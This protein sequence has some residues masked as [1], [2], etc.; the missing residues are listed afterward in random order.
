MTKTMGSI[1]WP[2]TLVTRLNVKSLKSLDYLLVTLKFHFFFE[3]NSHNF[4]TKMAKFSTLL[5]LLLLL[6]ICF[7]SSSAAVLPSFAMA[8]QV[9][10]VANGGGGSGDFVDP[11][12]TQ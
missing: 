8:D 1:R 10:E 9:G 12:Q 11:T 3:A 5:S 4:P 2:L 6:A 7:L